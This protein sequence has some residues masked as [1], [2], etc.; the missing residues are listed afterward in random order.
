V[1]DQLRHMKIRAKMY[2]LL[3]RLLRKRIS[4]ERPDEGVLITQRLRELLEEAGKPISTTDS[5]RRSL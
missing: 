1:V 4:N 5:S 3:L 2:K